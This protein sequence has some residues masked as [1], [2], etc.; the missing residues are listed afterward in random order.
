[1]HRNRALPIRL[2]YGLLLALGL[3]CA[4]TSIA[5]LFWLTERIDTQTRVN[6]QQSHRLLLAEWSQTLSLAVRDYAYWTLAYEVVT[7]RDDAA[8]YEHLGSGATQSDLFDA[9]FFFTADGDPIYAFGPPDAEAAMAALDRDR[10]APFLSRLAGEAP[11]DYRPVS[12][13]TRWH[14]GVAALTAAWVTPDAV[15]TV[16]AAADGLPIMVGVRLIDDRALA[17]LTRATG[18]ADAAIGFD[19]APAGRDSLVLTG[20]DGPVGILSW[21]AMR[22]GTRLRAET[23]PAV[24][25]LSVAMLALC[26]AAGHLFRRQGQRLNEAVR[27]ASTD[28]LT[29]LLNR[30]GLHAGLS[31]ATY[32]DAQQRG[33]LA[34]ITIDLNEFKQLNDSRGHHA[35]DLALK[36]TAERMQ[37]AFRE[38]DL[39]A[40][41]GGDEFV[42]VIVAEDPKS[43]ALAAGERIAALCRNPIDLGPETVALRP[44]IGVAVGAPGVQW[45]TLF[46]QSD[47]AM[48]WAKHKRVAD[49]VL[50]TQ[51]M[52]AA[53]GP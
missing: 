10:V 43:V 52:H 36:V 18:V 32:R 3:V 2:V 19:G 20:L 13:L 7:S 25:A 46:G 23:L 35:G 31:G 50:F 28:Q 24:L 30:A 4:G 38:E 6:L 49:P 12:G 44:A 51:S 26:L 40:R 27:L 5:I 45:E 37:R 14:D 21:Q 34:V 22:P 42:C 39:I 33:R 47:A 17:N 15:E 16:D 41:L 48:Y 29:G 1:M 9:I 11:A 8:V 53:D